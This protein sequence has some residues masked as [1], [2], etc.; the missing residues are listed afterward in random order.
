M[1]SLDF[2]IDILYNSDIEWHET[3]TVVLGPGDPIGAEL[4]SVAIA[5]I[6]I[7]DNDVSGSMVLPAPPVVCIM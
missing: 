5:T 7:L 2:N 6:T 4:G 1:R 3:F